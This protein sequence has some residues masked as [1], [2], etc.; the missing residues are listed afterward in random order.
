VKA[1]GDLSAATLATMSLQV[2]IG[3]DSFLN[4]SDWVPTGSGW[5]LVLPG[6]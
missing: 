6:E 3:N 2:T 4:Q 5:K 1:Y